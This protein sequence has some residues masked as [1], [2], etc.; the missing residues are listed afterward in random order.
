MM[1]PGTV[2]GGG[3]NSVV[4]IED[5]LG[6]VVVPIEGNNGFRREPAAMGHTIGVGAGVESSKMLPLDRKDL[7]R[8]NN[9]AA[10][11]LAHAFGG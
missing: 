7:R 11:L 4:D 9:P 2:I 8:W 10:Y 3:F 5:Q 1:T 6:H